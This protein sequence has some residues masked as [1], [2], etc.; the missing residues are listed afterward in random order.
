M[1]L[2]INMREE[3]IAI[4]LRLVDEM[5]PIHVKILKYFANPK[6]TVMKTE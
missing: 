3:V 6:H 1:A 2:K 4:I 5:G